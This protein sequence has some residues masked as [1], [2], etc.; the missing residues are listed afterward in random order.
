MKTINYFTLYSHPVLILFSILFV[1]CAP[2]F[3]NFEQRMLIDA[4]SLFHAGNYEAAKLKYTKLRDTGPQSEPA[5]T[6]QYNLGYINIYY[7]NPSSNPEAALRE[8]KLFSALYP[9]DFRIGEVNSWIR[10]IVLMQSYK[11]EYQDTVS[12]I[13]QQIKDKDQQLNQARR[14]NVETVTES[15]RVCY[16]GRDSLSRKVKELEN[17]I[18]DLERKCQQAGR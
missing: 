12:K 5:R 11:K 16:E 6:A 9:E 8:F 4:D 3:I 2:K 10:L 1:G 13:E 14:V 18:V 17:V 7:Q 15:L